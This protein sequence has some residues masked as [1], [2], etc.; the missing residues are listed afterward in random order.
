MWRERSNGVW[1]GSMRRAARGHWPLRGLPGLQAGSMP[2][3]VGAGNGLQHGL[4]HL[5]PHQGLLLSPLPAGKAPCHTPCPGQVSQGSEG[6][7]PPDTPTA[8]R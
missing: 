2:E 1:T 3:R 6:N 5:W 4:A 7:P 8:S